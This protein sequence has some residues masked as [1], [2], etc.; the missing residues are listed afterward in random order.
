MPTTLLEILTGYTVIIKLKAI[1]PIVIRTERCQNL[2]DVYYGVIGFTVARSVPQ[3][4]RGRATYCGASLIGIGDVNRKRV[5][6]AGAAPLSH[7]DY[8]VPMLIIFAF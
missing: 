6:V 1:D 7:H 3:L 4:I 8:W 2:I 5:K